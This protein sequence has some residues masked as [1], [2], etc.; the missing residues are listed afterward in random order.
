MWRGKRWIRLAASDDRGLRDDLMFPTVLPSQHIAVVND[1]AGQGG[2][3]DMFASLLMIQGTETPMNKV[4]DLKQTLGIS[5]INRK[6]IH[7]T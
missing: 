2:K 3:P 5:P 4:R 7:E 1:T 6:A